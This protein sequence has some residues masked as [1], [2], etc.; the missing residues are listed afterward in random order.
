MKR[1][2]TVLGI[3]TLLSLF[4]PTPAFAVSTPSE[5]TNY[6]NSTLSLITA[7]ASVAA[8]FFLIKGGYTYMSSS[9]NPNSLEG[10]KRTIKNALIGLVIVLAAGFIV[11]RRDGGSAV[12]RGFA[13]GCGSAR[14]GA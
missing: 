3:L 5:I 4:I 10:A 13:T 11:P 14:P 7:I 6:T 12:A 8:V 1:L 2:L 9:G